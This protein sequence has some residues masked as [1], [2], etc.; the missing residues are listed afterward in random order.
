[1]HLCSLPD[2]GKASLLGFGVA[3]DLALEDLHVGMRH[4]TVA[5]SGLKEKGA[6]SVALLV[7]ALEAGLVSELD[8]FDGDIGASLKVKR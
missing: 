4:A 3:K 2:G 6:S 5:V 1:V 7:A 8:W